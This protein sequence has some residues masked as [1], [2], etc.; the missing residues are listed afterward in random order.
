MGEYEPADSRT[1][2]QSTYT[3]PGEPPRT[4]PRE[5]AARRQAEQDQAEERSQDAVQQ[6]IA[7]GAIGRRAGLG[8][9]PVPPGDYPSDVADD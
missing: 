4:G 9:A 7:T 1:V 2:T 8:T 5:D 3:A 6:D